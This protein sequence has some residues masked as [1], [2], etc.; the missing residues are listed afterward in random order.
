MLYCIV[1]YCISALETARLVGPIHTLLS[2]PICL[3]SGMS[4]VSLEAESGKTSAED[5]QMDCEEADKAGERLSEDVEQESVENS[6]ATDD[7]DEVL[8]DIDID[9]DEEN[10]EN[11]D[12]DVQMED[13]GIQSEGVVSCS[14]SDAAHMSDGVENGGH[15]TNRHVETA[16]TPEESGDSHTETK[17]T[18]PFTLDNQPLLARSYS[19]LVHGVVAACCAAGGGLFPI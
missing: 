16:E 1:L 3:F 12:R 6:S 14:G 11:G 10:V 8:Y 18:F 17:V 9:S 19:A 7:R 4:E 5:P 13:E 15:E 2:A